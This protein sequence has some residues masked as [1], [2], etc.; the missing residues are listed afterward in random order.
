MIVRKDG[1]FLRQ[2]C[3]DPLRGSDLSWRNEVCFEA[4]DIQRTSEID[5]EGDEEN[6]RN[7]TVPG[8][9]CLVTER[10]KEEWGEGEQ[11]KTDESESAFGEQC[12]IEESWEDIAYQE[13]E[14]EREEKKDELLFFEAGTDDRTSEYERKEKDD[15]HGSRSEVIDIVLH[16]T[17]KPLPT[18]VIAVDICVLGRKEE[19]CV[20]LCDKRDDPRSPV[21]REGE[22]RGK[23]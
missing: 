15:E 14:R 11:E 5:E 2:I 1:M 16:D 18:D 19:V 8:C 4:V 23:E 12:D 22:D 9:R 20:R 3:P 13:E 21:G 17:E 7:E 6:I 10:D